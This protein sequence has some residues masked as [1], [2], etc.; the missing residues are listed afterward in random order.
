MKTNNMR[1]WSSV[2]R[3]II[4]IIVTI[5][6]SGCASK[7]GA[8]SP[9]QR[10]DDYRYKPAELPFKPINIALIKEKNQYQQKTSNI[11]ILID[12]KS[13][14]KELINKTLENLMATM[15]NN[16]PYQQEIVY[17]DDLQGLLN[18]SISNQDF[19]SSGLEYYA[20]QLKH[21]KIH[22]TI[23]TLTDWNKITDAT[24]NQSEQLFS[25]LGNN[26]C[27]YMIGVNNIH[28]NKRLTRP[29]H[30]GS[31]S[32]TE[33]LANANKMADFVERIFLTTPK[34]SDKDGIY[35]YKDQ[36]PDTPTEIPINWNGC[37]RNS[38]TSNPRYL[39]KKHS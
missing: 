25:K 5:I 33:S 37:P 13:D 18:R 7:P 2:M 10:S 36:C 17:R 34:D 3:I 35:N 28:K 8:I 27:L 21:S 24:L 20:E 9:M 15:P 23:I 29:E 16:L 38:N 6:I 19:L 14:K 11:I 4:L 26:I 39:I 22:S 32:S 12:N 30:C 31:S 1:L